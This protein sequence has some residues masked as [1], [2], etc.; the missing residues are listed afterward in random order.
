MAN[1][2]TVLEY[3]SAGLTTSFATVTTL[4]NPIVIFMVQNDSNVAAMISFN[5][6][7][8]TNL[9]VPAGDRQVLDL[10]VAKKFINGAI[11]MKSTGAGTGT[12]YITG[13]Y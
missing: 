8:V 6:S 2:S 3:N 4:T 5:L 9:I 11:Q 10:V 13:V 1:F 7:G 12:I